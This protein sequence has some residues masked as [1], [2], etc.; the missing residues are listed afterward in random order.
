MMEVLVFSVGIVVGMWVCGF[1]I[2]SGL[3]T[4]R[5]ID[6]IKIAGNSNGVKGT[7]RAQE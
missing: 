5:E 3:R 4:R 1:A 2:G 7:K 6:G